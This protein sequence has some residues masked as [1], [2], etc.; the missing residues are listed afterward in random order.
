MGTLKITQ[1]NPNFWPLEIA[2]S[3][4]IH[5]GLEFDNKLGLEFKIFL[6]GVQNQNSPPGSQRGRKAENAEKVLVRPILF[7]VSLQGKI[8]M[9][10]G[11]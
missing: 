7:L 6:V 3:F 5:A 4:L 8:T 9:N 11:H 1:I 2:P 10:L